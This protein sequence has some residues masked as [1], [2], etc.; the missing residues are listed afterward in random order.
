MCKLKILFTIFLLVQVAYCAPPA[1]NNQNETTIE[2]STIYP[3]DL[4]AGDLGNKLRLLPLTNSIND[5]AFELTRQLNNASSNENVAFSPVSISQIFSMIL[6]S[7]Q[8]ETRNELMNAFRYTEQLQT[9]DNVNNAFKL[10]LE[11]YEQSKLEEIKRPLKLSLPSIALYSTDFNIKKSFRKNL[12]DN[13]Q[14]DASKIDFKSS[15]AVNVINKFVN[16]STNGLIPKIIE[17]LSPDTKLA[18][19]NAFYYKGDWTKKFDS[20][21]VQDRTFHN[22]DQTTSQVK[23][24]FRRDYYD[25]YEDDDIQVISMSYDG[26]ATMIILMPHKG[27]SVTNLI[28]NLNSSVA[29]EYRDK[30]REFQVELYLPKFKLETSIDLKKSLSDLGVK[31]IFGN[32]AELS[33]ISSTNVYVS[34][35]VHKAFI[36]VDEE[37]TK[38]AA[39]TAIIVSTKSFGRNLKRMQIDRPFVFIIYDQ[40]NNVILFNGAVNKL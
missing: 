12:R 17:K 11:D 29:D 28:K 31:K 24:M 39:T 2:E 40:L 6:S 16:E 1:T 26:N 9:P 33:G 5:F 18:L 25:Y 23:M 27:T 34:E 8:N 3:N 19:V 37:G 21:L 13:Y 4:F 7:A 20:K 35:V 36:K 38:A 14:T 22:A 10:L 32:E 30:M 15:E